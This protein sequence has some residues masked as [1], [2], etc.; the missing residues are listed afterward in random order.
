MEQEEKQDNIEVWEDYVNIKDLVLSLV[1]CSLTSVGGYIIAPAGQQ[2]L[3]FGLVGAVLGFIIST[4][5]IKPKR[6][7][8]YTNDE[9]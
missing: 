8:S 6:Q 2:P 5:L 3:I 1:V 7:F 9:A 4:I